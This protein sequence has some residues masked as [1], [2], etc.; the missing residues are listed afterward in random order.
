MPRILDPHRTEDVIHPAA[1]LEEVLII[2]DVYLRSVSLDLVILHL[3]LEPRSTKRLYILAIV[4][5]VRRVGQSSVS[6]DWL[7]R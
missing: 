7:T 3:G 1:V 5:V 6:C 4:I 2:L